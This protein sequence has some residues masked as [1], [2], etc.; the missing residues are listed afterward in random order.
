[1]SAPPSVNPWLSIPVA[2]Y[3]NHMNSPAVRQRQFLNEIFRNT[4]EEFQPS[5]AVIPGCTTGNGFEH[6]DPA[7]TQ[8]ITGIDI[9]PLYL[10][11]LFRRFG[12]RLP[13]LTLVCTDINTW[14]CPPA[15]ADLIHCALVLEY[16]D[17]PR[18]MV[19]A[20]RWLRPGGVLSVV[21]Q[22]P[23]SGPGNV[24]VTPFASVRRLE[25]ILTLRDPDELTTLALRTG[26]RLHRADVRSLLTSKMFF[27]ALYRLAS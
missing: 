2:D 18:F 12:R 1:M 5:S 25:S 3:E 15:S 27:V 4:V 21:T 13:G 22:L 11:V 6:I 16:I 9:N 10:G 23:S 26:L 17:P 20:A 7:V 14:E 19:R 24:T 8:S